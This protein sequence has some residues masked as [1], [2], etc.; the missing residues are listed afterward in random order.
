[1]YLVFRQMRFAGPPKRGSYDCDKIHRFLQALCTLFMHE[2]KRLISA[3][4]MKKV[5]A[6]QTAARSLGEVQTH[7]QRFKLLAIAAYV[8][9]QTL[10]LSP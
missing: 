5:K 4:D 6:N 9:F 8:A 7:V 2:S 1:M 10:S 3:E